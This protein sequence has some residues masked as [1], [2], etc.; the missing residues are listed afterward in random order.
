MHDDVSC[1]CFVSARAPIHL[2]ATDQK[3]PEPSMLD[4]VAVTPYSGIR[5]APVARRS[6][7]SSATRLPPTAVP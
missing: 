7:L 1:R 6:V 5:A 3:T 4:A 2:T